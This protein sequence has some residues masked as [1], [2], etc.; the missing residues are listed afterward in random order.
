ML[1]R[2]PVDVEEPLVLDVSELE[3]VKEGLGDEVEVELDVALLVD[4]DVLVPLE[5]LDAE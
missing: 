3:E 2:V 5:V 4:E 1:E